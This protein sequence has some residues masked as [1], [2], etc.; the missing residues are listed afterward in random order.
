MSVGGII[1]PFQRWLQGCSR[2]C[3][4]SNRMILDKQL[5]L[6]MGGGGINFKPFNNANKHKLVSQLYSS[7]V[8]GAF[9]KWRSSTFAGPKCHVLALNPL[10]FTSW[11]TLAPPMSCGPTGA[12]PRS[13]FKLNADNHLDLVQSSAASGP[14]LPSVLFYR[15]LIDP[16]NK[17]KQFRNPDFFTLMWKMISEGTFHAS[18]S[19]PTHKWRGGTKQRSK[20]N[21]LCS[22]YGANVKCHH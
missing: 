9:L 16:S 14:E 15:V 10:I 13:S 3:S 8:P 20:W 11:S 22:K 19:P 2:L 1:E 17:R 12:N 18:I 6:L 4:H 5:L 7:Q 21:D